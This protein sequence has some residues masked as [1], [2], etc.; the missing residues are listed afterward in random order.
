MRLVV[1]I[2][3]LLLLGSSVEGRP[4][5]R[6]GGKAKKTPTA[7]R[8]AKK[9]SIV[10]RA[11]VP[12]RTRKQFADALLKNYLDKDTVPERN[13]PRI[14]YKEFVKGT[15]ALRKK[16]LLFASNEAFLAFASSRWTKKTSIPV[17]GFLMISI[18]L[19]VETAEGVETPVTLDIFDTEKIGL[20]VDMRSRVRELTAW[21]DPAG[22]P[23][24]TSIW[25][26]PAFEMVGK[27]GVVLY[28][29]AGAAVV[30]YELVDRNEF[31]NYRE[32]VTRDKLKDYELR[33]LLDFRLRKK[34]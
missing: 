8:M 27:G 23:S 6:G 16:R 14:S 17:R 13:L 3:A 18:H 7:K 28:K 21:I 9:K 10:K 24:E 26:E 20:H 15:A 4:V 12:H 34:D 5:R 11:V 29:K 2:T 1:S 32:G 31:R 33:G 30:E 19:L 25:E 22:S